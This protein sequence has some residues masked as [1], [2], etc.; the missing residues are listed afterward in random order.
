MSRI[1]IADDDLN[2]AMTCRNFLTKEENIEIVD[3]VSNGKDAISSYIAF[4]P[5]VLI[6]DLKMPDMNGVEVIN[7]LSTLNEEKQKNNIIVISGALNELM[8]YN[9]SMVYKI[10]PKPFSFDDLLRN[11]NE[12]QGDYDANML[13][14]TIDDLFY[15]LRLPS[16][17]IKGV[18]YLKQAVIF[19][20]NN[21]EL[22]YNISIVYTMIANNQ[23]GDKVKPK[24]VLWTL[25]SLTNSY[26]KCVDNTFLHSMFIY[27]Y[28][29]TRN[30]TPKYLI[31]LIVIHLKQSINK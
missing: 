13:K 12:I 6:L 28:D 22:F 5:D 4:Q 2:F 14:N 24:N 29:E 26:K 3:V 23:R 19:C 1:L 9:T 8:P 7:Q 10:M 31:E 21:E 18:D 27:Y 11:I 16:L 30:M 15:K 25:E 20:Y 17:A